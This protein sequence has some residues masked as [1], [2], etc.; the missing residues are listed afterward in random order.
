M[1]KYKPISSLQKETIILEK[2]ESHVARITLNRPEKRNAWNLK[3]IEDYFTTLEELEKDDF[4]KVVITTGTGPAFTAG[5]DL[6]E[7]R[8]IMLD[9]SKDSEGFTHYNIF[10]RVRL[11]P[12]VTIAAVNGICL[13]AGITLLVNHDIAIASLEKAKFGLPEISRGFVPRTQVS[14]LFKSIPRKWA[15]DMI[16]TGQ[17]FDALKALQAGLVSRVVSHDELEDASLSLASSIGSSPNYD[18]V[19]LKCTKLGAHYAMDISEYNLAMEMGSN[20][21][22]IA[23]DSKL[24][25]AT[26]A[27]QSIKR[28]DDP[29][30][31]S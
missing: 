13:G 11:Y 31:K 26:E 29:K 22:R 6:N 17:N 3:Q 25:L 12:K 28:E 1:G 16:L 2:Y 14:S 20:W 7:L 21:Y 30:P 24:G 10:D 9:P 15:F 18:P 19:V 5:R 8:L 4:V 27:L 23:R